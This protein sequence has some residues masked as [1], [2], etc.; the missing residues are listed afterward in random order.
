MAEE[1]LEIIDEN[2]KNDL[3][4]LMR[5]CIK[6]LKEDAAILP[7]NHEFQIH[8]FLRCL[9]K[10]NM[11]KPI[12][13]I[14]LPIQ[15]EYKTHLFYHRKS[16]NNDGFSYRSDVYNSLIPKVK[17]IN[18][19]QI[20]LALL[21]PTDDCFIPFQYQDKRVKKAFVGI[22]L[23]LPTKNKGREEAIFKK[24][25]IVDG[26][27]LTDAENKIDLKYLICIVYNPNLDFDVEKFLRE[28]FKNM[29]SESKYDE[30]N[31]AYFEINSDEKR[32]DREIIIPDNWLD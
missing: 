4:N 11:Q 17:H 8:G 9:L 21:C 24:H 26:K 22:E 10:S 16:G 2:Q 18:R 29:I 25:V 31:I 27:K 6:S 7:F 12:I 23:Q 3:K 30:L 13:N 1:Q 5:L 19:G 28:E 14:Q 32:I 15:H 20:D